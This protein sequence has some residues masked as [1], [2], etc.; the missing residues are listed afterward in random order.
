MCILCCPP[1]IH[2]RDLCKLIILESW[3]SKLLSVFSTPRK[4][5]LHFFLNAMIWANACI[6]SSQLPSESQCFTQKI[7]ACCYELFAGLIIFRIFFWDFLYRKEWEPIYVVAYLVLETWVWCS[8][9]W[10]WAKCVTSDSSVNRV[11]T[12]TN[13][14]HVYKILV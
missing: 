2:H 9:L 5:S 4:K 13:R 8:S 11:L 1:I 7:Y 6:W 3:H 12:K 14:A 10:F